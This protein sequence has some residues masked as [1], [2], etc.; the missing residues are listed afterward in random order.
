VPVPVANLAVL[1]EPLLA[2]LVGIAESETLEFK[3]D[4]YGTSDRAKQELCKD[5]SALANT[6]GGDIV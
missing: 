3:R 1:S 5:V 4:T 6:V 2:N